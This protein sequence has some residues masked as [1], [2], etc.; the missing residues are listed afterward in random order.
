V[1]PG[2]E[3][4]GRQESRARCALVLAATHFP[5]ESHVRGSA[6]RARGEV[7]SGG[8]LL[9]GLGGP[10]GVRLDR[11]LAVVAHAACG[12]DRRYL[13]ELSLRA[14]LRCEHGL[15]RLAHSLRR[16]LDAEAVRG[17]HR[18]HMLL[19]RVELRHKVGGRGDPLPCGDEIERLVIVAGEHFGDWLELHAAA[20]AD[21]QVAAAGAVLHDQVADRGPERAL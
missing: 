12:G 18:H 4:R 16:A 9:L 11:W 5:H 3:H 15:D 14:A 8:R 17:H 2:G 21:V 7:R 1:Q 6:A 13:I 19:E 10:L 20:G